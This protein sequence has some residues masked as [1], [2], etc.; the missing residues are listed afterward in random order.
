MGLC[1]IRANPWYRKVCDLKN[2]GRPRQ[3]KEYASLSSI[4]VGGFPNLGAPLEGTIGDMKGL[5]FRDEGLGSLSSTYV[6]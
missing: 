4:F 2:E 3:G 1:E 6:G 5:G